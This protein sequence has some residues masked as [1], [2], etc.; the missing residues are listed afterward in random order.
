MQK[1]FWTRINAEKAGLESLIY[2]RASAKICVYLLISSV[3]FE[4]RIY[5]DNRGLDFLK[6]LDYLPV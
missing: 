5:T 4:T 6:Y 3:L 2:L 1:L